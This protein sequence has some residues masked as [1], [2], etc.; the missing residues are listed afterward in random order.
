MG[1]YVRGSKKLL[2]QLAPRGVP[3]RN[4]GEGVTIT[5][6]APKLEKLLKV[7]EQAVRSMQ[8][9][10][11][12]M[13][14]AGLLAQAGYLETAATS[15]AAAA[16]DVNTAEDVAKFLAVAG[17]SVRAMQG[18]ADILRESSL[19]ARALEDAAGSLSKALHDA[20]QDTIP[21][22]VEDVLVTKEPG[23]K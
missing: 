9:E 3:D 16:H 6:M 13:R 10:A 2:A 19:A 18:A 20:S 11:D 15:L 12:T 23:G 4:S 17:R 14:E 7:A 5:P 8:A 22:S 1:D 21:L